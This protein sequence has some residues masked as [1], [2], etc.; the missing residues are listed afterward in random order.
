MSRHAL[1]IK[2]LI[3]TTIKNELNGICDYE[4]LR[5][6]EVSDLATLGTRSDTLKILKRATER[7]IKEIIA[8]EILSDKQ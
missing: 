3:L 4:I 8:Q 2:N 7:A 6:D 5:L 1:P